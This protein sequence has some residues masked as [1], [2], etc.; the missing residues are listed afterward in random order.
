MS[1]SY[2]PSLI[3]GKFGVY[4]LLN[5]HL[6]IHLFQADTDNYSYSSLLVFL[7]LIT[8][9]G[10]CSH[11]KVDSFVSLSYSTGPANPRIKRNLTFFRSSN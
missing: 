4:L 5:I 8:L 6:E 11:Q 9:T 10:D 1:I 2:F 3:P 7:S